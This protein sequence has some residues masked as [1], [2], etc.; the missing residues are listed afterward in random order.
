MEGSERNAYI[1][2]LSNPHLLEEAY[3]VQQKVKQYFPKDIHID[4]HYYVEYTFAKQ[5]HW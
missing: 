3:P 2:S 5:F 4:S 1:Q